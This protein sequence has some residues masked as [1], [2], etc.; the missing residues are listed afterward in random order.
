[1]PFYAVE[2]LS[3]LSEFYVLCPKGTPVKEDFAAHTNLEGH[4]FTLCDSNETDEL[5]HISSVK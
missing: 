3:A 4:K 5:W 2:D 1:M